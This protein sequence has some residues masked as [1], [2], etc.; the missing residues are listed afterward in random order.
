ME[1]QI[2]LITAYV[3]ELLKLYPRTKVVQQQI[4]YCIHETKLMHGDSRET[5]VRIVVFGE[6]IMMYVCHF[7]LDITEIEFIS[8]LLSNDEKDL[9]R[10]ET[11][12][13]RISFT[14]DNQVKI[15]NAI[16]QKRIVRNIA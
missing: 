3:A 5:R 16:R 10:Q 9:F 13:N 6:D 12:F 8:K 7:N 14:E 2:Q 1:K 15:Y 11:T 4:A